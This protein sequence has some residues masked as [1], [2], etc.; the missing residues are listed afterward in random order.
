ML[1]E[2]FWRGW[3]ARWLINADDFTAVKLGT[4]TT[5]SFLIASVLF[6]SEHGPYWEVGLLAGFIYNWWIMRTRSLADCIVAH[7]VTNAL[8]S[9]YVLKTGQWE[10]WM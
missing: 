2:I 10:Y 4:F 8:L 9:G 6:A 3:L 5:S 7:G 1:E